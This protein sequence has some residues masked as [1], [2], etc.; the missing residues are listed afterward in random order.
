M[1][2]HPTEFIFLSSNIKLLYIK[3]KEAHK[4]NWWLFGLILSD[5]AI[6]F[7]ALN[8]CISSE[9]GVLERGI[10]LGFKTRTHQ[11]INKNKYLGLLNFIF[12]LPSYQPTHHQDSSYEFFKH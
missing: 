6:A 8:A 9:Q 2:F 3:G 7:G 12:S 5:R 11:V 4:G 10:L 1:L